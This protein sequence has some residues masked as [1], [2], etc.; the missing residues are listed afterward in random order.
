MYVVPGTQVV[1]T[2][3]SVIVHFLFY[4]EKEC[5]CCMDV[6]EFPKLYWIIEV[7]LDFG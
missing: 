2:Q 6:Y 3:Y 4:D 1:G 5:F 7:C